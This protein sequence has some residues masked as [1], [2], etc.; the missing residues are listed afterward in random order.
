MNYEKLV[1]TA[2]SHAKNTGKWN[3][4]TSASYSEIYQSKILP[5]LGKIDLEEITENHCREAYNAIEREGF[6]TSAG[7]NGY[8]KS[9]L[10]KFRYL[11]RYPFIVGAEK[12]LCVDILWGTEFSIE[13]TEDVINNAGTKIR[14]YLTPSEELLI[15]K[16]LLYADY[17]DGTILG[18]LLMFAAGLRNEEACAVKYGHIHQLRGHPDIC[19]LYIF[20]SRG[21]SDDKEHI[22][23][24]SNN[25]FRIIPLPSNVANYLLQRKDSYPD[26]ENVDNL[27]IAYSR[28]DY[29]KSVTTDDLTREAKKLFQE[30]NIEEKMY[31]SAA[32]EIKQIN[33]TESGRSLNEKDPTAYLFRRNFATHLKSLGFEQEQIEYLLGHS[34][35]AEDIDRSHFGNPDELAKLAYRLQCRPFLNP[36]PLREFTISTSNEPVY[37]ENCI[38]GTYTMEFNDVRCL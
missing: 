20:T 6:Q 9:S 10:E 21:R 33:A 32:E 1:A 37:F 22:G 12:G 31:L 19:I 23:G 16:H 17:P 27:P 38:S 24:K 15:T 2:I 35:N 25:M 29:T 11:I 14:K 4:N 18:L 34:I 28:K 8:E 7:R 36:P 26:Q 3:T 5:H 30:I 13:Q